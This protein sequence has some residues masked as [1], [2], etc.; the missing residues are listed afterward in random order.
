MRRLPALS[1]LAPL[2]VLGVTSPAHAAESCQGQTATIV[3]TPDGSATG[4]EGD[5]VIVT[6]GA[7]EVFAYGGDDLVC[8]TGSPTDPF[9]YVSISAGDGDDVVDSSAGEHRLR[10]ELGKGVD[11]FSGGPGGEAVVTGGAGDGGESVSTGDGQDYVETGTTGQPMDNVISTGAG[12]DEIHFYGLPGTGSIDAGTE[13]DTVY[14]RDKTSAAWRIDNRRSRISAKG[15]TMR[16]VSAEEFKTY[17]LRWRSLRFTG[18]SSP[19]TLDLTDFGSNRGNG[20][21]RVDFG[22]GRDLAVI[23]RSTRGSLDGGGQADTLVVDAFGSGGVKGTARVDLRTG[24]TFLAGHRLSTTS[25]TR[26]SLMGFAENT[27]RGTAAG[28]W[29]WVQGCRATIH[30][31]GGADEVGFRGERNGC[32]AVP[33]ADRSLTAYGEAGPDDLRGHLGD[34]VL[35]GGPGKDLVKG[36]VGTDVCS[37]ETEIACP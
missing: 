12:K 36:G 9:E 37:A 3:G 33:E 6:A 28:N 30:A 25:F 13:R 32:Q 29:L 11:T 22:G 21:V 17:V 35:I 5:D 2:V 7:I 24:R 26:L 23:D 27:V 20:P 15:T 31:G 10:A 34:D 16:F 14:L 18:S 8:V 19:E 4:T 1:L